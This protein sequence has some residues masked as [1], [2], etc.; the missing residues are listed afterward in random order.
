MARNKKR[1]LR[2]ALN[3]IGNHII[4]LIPGIR[5]RFAHRKLALAFWWASSFTNSDL[6]RSIR[7]RTFFSHIDALRGEEPLHL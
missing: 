2:N 1:I 4:D 3:V 5:H 7:C 6:F